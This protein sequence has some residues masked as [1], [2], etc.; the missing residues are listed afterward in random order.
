[1]FKVKLDNEELI[2]PTVIFYTRKNGHLS[3]NLQFTTV[4]ISLRSVTRKVETR[5]D[6]LNSKILQLMVNLRGVHV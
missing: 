3:K 1:M 4:I 2:V 6:G 5:I